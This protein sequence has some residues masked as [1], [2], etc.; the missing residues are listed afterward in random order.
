MNFEVLIQSLPLVFQPFNFS[1][2][3]IGMTVGLFFGALPG[4]SSSMGIVLMLP[5]TYSLGVIP[6]VILLASL[7]AGSAYGGSIT[8]ILFNTPGTPEAAATTFDGYPMAQK[9]QAGRALG[10]AVTAVPKK[11]IITLFLREGHPKSRTSAVS[12]AKELGIKPKK[13]K[14]GT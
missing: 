7:Y 5:F 10:L 4:I 3:I 13:F 11:P 12:R 2:I 14:A 8:A 1:L 6:S 9:G